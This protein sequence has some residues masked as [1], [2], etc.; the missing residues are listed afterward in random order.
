MQSRLHTAASLAAALLGLASAHAQSS[1]PISQSEPLSYPDDRTGIVN[2]EIG[3]GSGAIVRHPRIVVS[4]AHVVFDDYL[5][6][7]ATGWTNQND[8]TLAWNGDT[9]PDAEDALPLRGYIRFARYATTSLNPKKYNLA[10]SE[11]FIAHF[12]YANLTSSAPASFWQDGVAALKSGA[13]KRI[14]GYPA[15]LYEDGDPLQYRLHRTPDFPAKLT[16]ELGRYL[17]A[18]GPSTGSGNSGGPAWVYD[19]ANRQWKFAGVLVSGLETSQGDPA[20]EIG[21]VGADSAPWSLVTAAIQA[22][23]GAPLVKPAVFNTTATLP[24]AIPDADRSG[25]TFPFDVSVTG[26]RLTTLRI[27]LTSDHTYAEDLEVALRSPSGRSVVIAF[28]PYLD[29]LELNQREIVG[30]AG[31]NPNGRWTLLVRDVAASDTG[32]VTAASLSVLAQ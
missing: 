22:S 28:R 13:F 17:G 5:N 15:G 12:S 2:S 24:A 9:A 31:Q 26:K 30:L 18:V 29:T 8:F 23:G 16:V 27:T 7:G 11:D 19:L 10:F 32:S 20:N 25:V 14:T 3:Q 1:A 6:T 4:C 21:V